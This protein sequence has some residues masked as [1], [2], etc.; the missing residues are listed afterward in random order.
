MAD[1]FEKILLNVKDP[2]PV[3]SSLLEKIDNAQAFCKYISSKDFTL[4]HWR[5]LIVKIF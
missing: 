1:I 5:K 3:D 4:D 2:S